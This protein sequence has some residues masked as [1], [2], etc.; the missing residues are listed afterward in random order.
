MARMHKMKYQDIA[1]LSFCHAIILQISNY[2]HM[3][4]LQIILDLTCARR[5]GDAVLERTFLSWKHGQPSSHVPFGEAG[6]HAQEDVGAEAG[7][8]ISFTPSIPAPLFRI[9]ERAFEHPSKGISLECQSCPIGACLH[10]DPLRAVRLGHRRPEAASQPVRSHRGLHPLLQGQR[11]PNALRPLPEAR[12]AGR[13]RHRE[14]ACKRIVGN[15]CKKSGCRWSKVGAN[16]VL[17][18]RCCFE[19]M[20]WPDFLEWRACRA[21][22]A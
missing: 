11:G 10:A 21:A 22:V 12:T 14:S 16:A 1:I 20:R 7:F 9:T 19:N 2:C 6:D 8:P 4:T 5:G 13:I 15:R 17:A 18:I 3:Q